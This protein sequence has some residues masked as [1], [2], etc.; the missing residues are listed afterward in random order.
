MKYVGLVTMVFCSPLLMSCYVQPR[1]YVAL[2]ECGEVFMARACA[3]CH[4]ICGTEA[5]GGV[6]PD[7]THVASRLSLAANTLE[8]GNANLMAWVTHAQ[9]LKPE[10]MMPNVTQMTGEDLHALVAFLERLE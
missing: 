1:V 3:L 4:T 5:Q 9:S 8:T 10:V 6:A 7:L 2:A